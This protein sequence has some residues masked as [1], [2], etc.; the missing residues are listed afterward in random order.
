MIRIVRKRTT[1]VFDLIGSYGYE[2]CSS[3]A[4]SSREATTAKKPTTAETLTATGTARNVGN[5]SN[6][7]GLNSSREG[8]RDSVRRRGSRDEATSVRTHQQQT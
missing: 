7:R 3:Q 2:R 1:F 6:R 8:S 5:N 4:N